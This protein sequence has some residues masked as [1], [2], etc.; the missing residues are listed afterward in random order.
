[1][2]QQIGDISNSVLHDVNT[3]KTD[4][5]E[6][7]DNKIIDKSIIDKYSCWKHLSFYIFLAN[8]ACLGFNMYYICTHFPRVPDNLGFDYMGIIV[9]ILSFL[10]TLLIGWNIFSVIDFNK[11]VEV[12]IENNNKLKEEREVA[13]KKFLEMKDDLDN[14]QADMTFRS[15]LNNA[16]NYRSVEKEH[17]VIDEYIDAL[18][19]AIKDKLKDN[20][21]TIA[22]NMLHSFLKEQNVVRILPERK[23]FYCDI[24][25]EIHPKN[26]RIYFIIDKIR[27][28][29]EVSNENIGALFL[30]M[31]SE[32]NPDYN[33][34]D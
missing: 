20:R 10:I 31:L 19:V 18:N 11:K 2:N 12:I 6:K 22:I 33:N 26:E 29:E 23:E 32:H 4:G 34:N 24:L 30:R 13:N 9:G 27:T 7:N 3:N 5:S 15:I 8:I 28:A 17:Y 16:Y 14:L 25:D 21:I 1:M